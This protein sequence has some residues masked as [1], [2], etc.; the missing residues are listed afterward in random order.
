MNAQENEVICL[1]GGYN[2]VY[3]F[4]LKKNATLSTRHGVFHAEDIIYQTYGTTI[5]ARNKPKKSLILLKLTAELNTHCIDY[6][7]Q[8]V[9]THDIALA[10]VWLNLFSGAKIIETG[11][12]SGS[13]TVSFARSVG[14]NGRVY[15]F[16]ANSDRY[17][18]FRKLIDDLK[19]TNVEIENRDVYEKGLQPSAEESENFADGVFLDLPEPW[20]V[21]K[22]VKKVLKPC[23]VVVSFSPSIEQVLE[24]KEEMNRQG[25]QDIES[26]EIIMQPWGVFPREQMDEKRR[27]V[28][29]SRQN[30]FKKP[31]SLELPMV[32]ETSPFALYAQESYPHTGYLI[33]GC[34]PPLDEDGIDFLPQD[35]KSRLRAHNIKAN[36]N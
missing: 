2:E 20:R 32:F 18:N 16:E 36:P 34:Q 1:F 12:G 15:T 10:T 7:T 21:L 3:R 25:F 13:V 11:T 33:M 28:Q 35:S 26:I 30:S 14:S 31:I 27:K 24:T 23:S 29:D 8:I 6:V 22:H 19:L 5:Y 4:K 9:Y 17:Q